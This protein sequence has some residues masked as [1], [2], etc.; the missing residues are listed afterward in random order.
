MNDV[1]ERNAGRFECGDIVRVTRYGEIRH[2]K[3]VGKMVNP[4]KHAGANAKTLG[5]QAQSLRFGGIAR[6]I[7]EHLEFV[8]DERQLD[9]QVLQIVEVKTR[10]HHDE[11]DAILGI[12]VESRKRV[13]VTCVGNVVRIRQIPALKNAFG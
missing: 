13:F 7:K 2:G 8:L 10:R 9:H 4:P 1:D 11:N 5:V 3:G 6:M 12:E